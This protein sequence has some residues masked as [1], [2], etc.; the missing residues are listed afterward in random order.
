M[1][2]RDFFDKLYQ[3]WARTTYAKDRYWDFQPDAAELHQINAVGEE[4][5]S[6]P[7]AW[8]LYEGDAD[9]ITALH[10]CFPDLHRALNEALDEADRLDFERDKQEIRIAELEIEV[11]DL[12]DDLAG[13]VG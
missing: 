3:M 13:L 1:E 5:D 4:G 9:W 10:G 6:I 11:A 8:G 2:S 7:V 12:K